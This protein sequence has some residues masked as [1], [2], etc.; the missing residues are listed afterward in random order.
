MRLLE[1][2]IFSCTVIRADEETG[3][4]HAGDDISNGPLTFLQGKETG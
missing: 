2:G 4:S 1:S 3:L